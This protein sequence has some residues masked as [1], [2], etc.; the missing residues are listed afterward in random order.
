[1][2]WRPVKNYEKIYEV[3][4]FGQV[5]SLD[6]IEIQPERKRNGFIVKEFKRFR[7]GKIINE[8][9]TPNGR[10]IVGLYKDGKLRRMGVH[11]LVYEAFVE[12]I[13]KGNIIHHKDHDKQNNHFS[14]LQ[15]MNFKEHNN[16]HKHPAWNK[17]IPWDKQ[18]IQKMT[19]SRQWFYTAK[20]IE[21]YKK[22]EEAY[23]LLQHGYTHQEIAKILCVSRSTVSNRIKEFKLRQKSLSN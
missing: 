14:N 20:K 4:E 11:I 18:S 15:Q 9:L 16:I 12:P 1:M 7:A 22:Q 13:K 21:G 17:G 3:S 23:I 5:R 10:P 19:A 8:N 2:E 6:R